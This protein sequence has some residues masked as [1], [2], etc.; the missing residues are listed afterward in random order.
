[1]LQG[2]IGDILLVEGKNVAAWLFSNADKKVRNLREEKDTRTQEAPVAPDLSS[3]LHRLASGLRDAPR[4]VLALRKKDG[5]VLRTVKP[6]VALAAAGLS[7]KAEELMKDVAFAQVWP[8]VGP[9]MLN[10]FRRVQDDTGTWC[11]V[12]TRTDA[13]DVWLPAGYYPEAA[14]EGIQSK[15]PAL[16]GALDARTR[17]LVN[18]LEGQRG[19]TVY[20]AVAEYAIAGQGAAKFLGFREI[21]TSEIRRPTAPSTQMFDALNASAFRDASTQKL[22]GGHALLSTSETVNTALLP[23]V[24]DPVHGTVGLLPLRWGR[25]H[26]EAEKAAQAPEGANW[27]Q[28]PRRFCYGDLCGVTADYPDSLQELGDAGLIETTGEEKMWLAT[29]SGLAKRHL[30]SPQEVAA[31]QPSDCRA[32]AV[33]STGVLP[34][35]WLLEARGAPALCAALAARQYYFDFENPGEVVQLAEAFRNDEE[36]YG[37]RVR[38]SKWKPRYAYSTAPVCAN[39][40]RCYSAVHRALRALRAGQGEWARAVLAEEAS[41]A[42]AR[43]QREAQEAADSVR[44]RY[45]C[46]EV[47]DHVGDANRRRTFLQE[48][49]DGFDPDAD[50]AA[51]V[52][53]QRRSTV[54]LHRASTAP[55]LGDRRASSAPR[56][57]LAG[58]GQYKPRKSAMM[59]SSTFLKPVEVD[60]VVALVTEEKIKRKSIV[61]RNTVDK[62]KSAANKLTGLSFKRVDRF[63]F[64]E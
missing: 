37:E 43:R 28:G 29:A 58:P 41:T 55:G 14:A 26:A 19:V 47:F 50:M 23:E 12:Q 64:N 18:M 54:A 27:S 22:L 35:S 24:V 56:K 11:Q 7:G 8:A 51:Q 44:N 59:R 36:A 21:E 57:T 63:E 60:G 15:N 42:V 61:R 10:T 5:A 32:P 53:E 3:C 62:R 48:L 20:F 9:L 4:S 16:N 6:A 39:C 31:V 1:M 2:E 25:S 30:I 45:A 40:L 49:T 34:V 17:E 38:T 33:A 52:F 46:D 13:A